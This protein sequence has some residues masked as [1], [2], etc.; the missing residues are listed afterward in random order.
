[1]GVGAFGGQPEQVGGAHVGA[2]GCAADQGGEGAV[3]GAVSLGTAQPEFEDGAAP[4]GLDPPGCFGGDQGLVVELVEQRRFHNLGHGHGSAHEGQGCIG[5]DDPAFGDG[6]E[7]QPAKIAVA[8]QIAKK[9]VGEEAIA[10]A[11]AV[12]AQKF[13]SGVAEV[14]LLQ[15]FQKPFEPGID[16]VAGLVLVV[17]RVAAE[18][19]VEL[20]LQFVQAQ[21]KIELSHGKLVLVGEEN[22]AH[23]G[24]VAE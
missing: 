6:V 8:A 10:L 4:A 20:H 24:V 1:M 23:G 18:E 15:P 11:V 5:V 22:P 17:V 13:E 2:E 9:I 3:V 16:A 19:V 14:G 7:A 21:A 12:V